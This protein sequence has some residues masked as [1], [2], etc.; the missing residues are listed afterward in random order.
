MIYFFTE[1][2]YS[3]IKER[4]GKMIF[5]VTIQQMFVL[6]SLILLGYILMKTGLL[7]KNSET[8]LSKLENYLF[9]PALV[10]STFITNFTVEKISKTGSLLAFSIIIEFFIII[11]ALLS[12]RLITKDSYIRKIYLYGL[13]FSNFGFMGN[14]VVNALFPD[15]F[16]EYII[17]TLVLWVAIYLWGVPTLL[18][19]SENGGIKS[20]LKNLLNPMLMCMVLGIIIG[21]SGIKLPQFTITLIDSASV[22][23]S[24]VAMLI[25]GMTIAKIDIKSVLKVKSLYIVTLLRLFAFPLAFVGICLALKGLFD[26]EFS[27]TFMICAVA[28]LAM[29]LGLNTIVIPSAY[30]KDT[31]VASGMA[32]VSHILSIASIPL[33]FW[34]AGL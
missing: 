17:F 3:Y 19:E 30:G 22:C 24:P 28:S 23:M 25:T 32:L 11:V 6:C 1:K 27:K 5:S 8:V 9:L 29:P 20:K 14:A 15:I 18:M 16:M 34:L 31:T 12:T 13:C 21:I 7:P 4:R 10:L 33:V 26:I 2:L